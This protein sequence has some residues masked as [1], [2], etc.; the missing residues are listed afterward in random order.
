MS[1]RHSVW[2]ARRGTP[3][4]ACPQPGA[5]LGPG[6]TSPGRRR[7]SPCLPAPS[8][9]PRCP[10]AWPAGKVGLTP[11]HPAS[12]GI[13]LG[14]PCQPSRPSG[15]RGTAK[16]WIPVLPVLRASGSDFCTD[17]EG[18]EE[19]GRAPE[20]AP[21]VPLPYSP[22]HHG[23]RPPQ[24]DPRLEGSFTWPG[25]S[26]RACGCTGEEHLEGT[27]RKVPP[28]ASSR[29]S[30]QAFS[31][32][33]PFSLPRE[34]VKQLSSRACFFP[35]SPPSISRTRSPSSRGRYLG[36]KPPVSILLAA[37]RSPSQPRRGA[38]G[39]PKATAHSG[40]IRV[41]CWF[42]PP[43]RFHTPKDREEFTTPQKGF[44]HFY[45]VAG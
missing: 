27:G 25:L 24:G 9:S 40:C 42:L 12:T 29:P 11:R 20:P 18:H 2:L 31:P 41:P 45:G 26:P 44:S 6:E 30:G 37:S 43:Q 32:S 13:P 22:P 15:P 4:G 23:C 36:P 17:P 10:T 1:S 14:G 16:L 3:H 39:A 28:A 19:R 21:R 34:A 38:G 35:S 33:S 8:L 7:G 5:M